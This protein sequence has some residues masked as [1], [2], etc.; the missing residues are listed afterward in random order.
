[1]NH[2]IQNL[3]GG[4]KSSAKI[5]DRT[6]LLSLPD[7]IEPVVWRMDLGTAKSSAIEVR[8]NDNGQ[9][10]LV[11]KTPKTDAHLIATYDFKIK[12]TRALMMVT[13]AMSKADRVFPTR[14]DNENRYLPVPIQPTT[15]HRRNPFYWVWKIF[16][17]GL[18]LLS[19]ILV[20][21]AGII[22]AGAAQK[23][24][25]S[26]ATSTPNG[27]PT[28]SQDTSKKKVGELMSADDFLNKK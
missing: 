26:V 16:K 2:M 22:V 21:F 9:Y 4:Y 14:G 8:A 13:G 27:T 6:L 23:Q 15:K 10:D 17:Y 5:V 25:M 7:A 18:I 1:M 24:Y 12:A 19:V 28:V 20:I 11:L 3:T